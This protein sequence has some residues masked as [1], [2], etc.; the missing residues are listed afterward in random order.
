[1]EG[2]SSI[3]KNIL[4]ALIPIFVAVDAIGTLPIF[5]SFTHDFSKAERRKVIV[6]SMITAGFLAILFVFLGKLIFNALG[7]EIGDFMIAGGVVLLCIA[8]LDI[9]VPE[10]KRRV[11]VKDIGVVPLGTPLIA[12]PAVLTTSLIIISEYGLIATLIS[13]VVNIGIAG[14]IFSFSHIL[15]RLLGN[16]GS[17]A[18]SKVTSLF[19]SAIAVMMIRKGIIELFS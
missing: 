4:F 5:V 15:I 7:I 1:L 19:L 6:Q 8:V 2:C 14:L 17:K 9:I 10:K 12:G 3:I 18:L 11:P 13:V 16:A